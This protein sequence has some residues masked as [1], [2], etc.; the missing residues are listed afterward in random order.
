[1]LS[2]IG[3]KKTLF[4]AL[5]V[6][7]IAALLIALLPSSKADT[8]SVKVVEELL[9]A[10]AGYGTINTVFTSGGAISDSGTES[11][12]LAGSVKLRSWEVGEGDYVEAGDLLATV[13]RSSVLQAISELDEL[14][15][16][17]D[18]ALESSR[19][20]TVSSVLYS[21]IDGTVTKVY[22]E[23]GADVEDTVY[24]NGALIVLTD[25]GG[26]EVNV[27]GYAGTVSAVYVSE[28]DTVYAGQSLIYLTDTEYTGEYERLLSQRRELE[29]QMQALFTAYERGGVYAESSGRVTG[30]NEDIISSTGGSTGTG[31]HLAAR[32]LGMPQR[33]SA[34]IIEP[35]SEDEG[36]DTGESGT[37]EPGGSEEPTNPDPVDPNPNPEPGD[38]KTTEKF[39]KVTSV[40]E[41]AGTVTVQLTDGSSLT[42]TSA[43]LEALGA[44]QIK[45]G[46]I[47][48]LGYDESGALISVTVYSSGGQDNTDGSGEMPDGMDSS[49][50][51]GGMAGGGTAA[52]ADDTP[53]DYVMGETELCTLTDYDTAEISL[54]VDELDIARLSIGQAVTVT[55]DALPGQSFDGEITEID[56]N[57]ENSGGSTKYSV[58][59]TL[60]RTEDMLTGMNAA[61]R[62]QLAE[63]N[64]LLL[65]P[66]AA[67]QEDA[68]GIYVCTGYD[69]SSDE[70]TDPVEITTGLSDGE[71]VEVLSGLSEGDTI[72][73]RY[74]D[75]LEY[76]F[77]R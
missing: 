32:L 1:M 51:G 35:V 2:K 36:E 37:T 8:S 75:T 21:P 12:A 6:V 47:L 50:G 74:A 18:T 33:L 70:T 41:E 63:N 24:N 46:D 62:V 73:Y 14:M 3:K 60:P 5:A 38:G 53:K 52:A 66:L 39:G 56:P 43:E 40:D 49:M 54:T 22:A 58:T 15:Q 17:L 10:K 25:S 55:L 20:D 29:A 42:L 48:A 44:S 23:S 27:V 69:K 65:I 16:E 26:R 77:V 34:M 64:D 45:V 72:Y 68:D 30:L 19:S 4:A 76:S 71:N 61:V 67:V 11:I 9:S 28:G 59:V 7:L 57:G 13:D 31:T